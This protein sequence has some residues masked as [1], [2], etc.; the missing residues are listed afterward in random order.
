MFKEVGTSYNNVAP[1]LSSHDLHIKLDV[2]G[3]TTKVTLY[4]AM[5]GYSY[6]HIQTSAKVSIQDITATDFNNFTPI[7]PV[8]S[9]SFRSPVVESLMSKNRIGLFDETNN[10]RHIIQYTED[11]KLKLEGVNGTYI[12]NLIADN[13]ALGDLEITGNA[14]LKNVQSNNIIPESTLSWDLGT[15]DL[16]WRVLYV[17]SINSGAIFPREDNSFDIGHSA[18]KWR[19][20]YAN[21]IYTNSVFIGEENNLAATQPWVGEKIL[22][23]LKKGG[24]YIGN[25]CFGDAENGD[26]I[27]G[28]NEDGEESWGILPDGRAVF[29]ELF[30]SEEGKAASQTWTL[31]N[32]TVKSGGIINLYD[33]SF[34]ELGRTMSSLKNNDIKLYIISDSDGN[35]PSI[36]GESYFTISDPTKTI[37]FGKSKPFGVSVGDILAVTKLQCRI[38]PL[39]DAKAASG[40][41]PGADGLESVWDKTQINKIAGI[42][43]TANAALPRVNVLPSKWESNMNNALD[44]GVYVWCTLGRPTG[45]TG[46]YTCITFRT[47][48]ND[49]NYDTI[50]Q[51]AYGR[52]A[53]LGKIFKRIIFYKSDGTDTQYGDWQEITT[54]SI[55][56]RL[57]ILENKINNT[58]QIIISEEAPSDTNLLWLKQIGTNNYGLY[59]YKEENWIPINNSVELTSAEYQSL[60]DAGKTEKG[61][62]YNV[63]EE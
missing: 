51:T 61:V 14:V 36:K 48:T 28:Y 37:L 55:I 1:S 30:I 5:D 24:F 44:T 15:K 58:K 53:E 7:Y 32:I 60:V 20:L 43:S 54:S 34:S 12:P 33:I 23:F 35:L 26:A 27:V 47:S 11:G 59:I 52:E 21:E 40:D 17:N 13:A 22:D 56:E 16:R 29:K 46:A 42:E 3:K 25:V 41:F 38:I 2:A 49:G 45:S 18:A 10:Y 8:L 4:V 62:I 9:Y 50:E 19:K 57:T 6:M 31:D 39:N 63:Y